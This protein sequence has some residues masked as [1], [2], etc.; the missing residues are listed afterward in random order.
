L[1]VR[2]WKLEVGSCWKYKK[3]TIRI[4]KKS[5]RFNVNH[6]TMEVNQNKQKTK[7]EVKK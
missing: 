2:S 6:G 4:T 1:E 3:S 5:L 7:E